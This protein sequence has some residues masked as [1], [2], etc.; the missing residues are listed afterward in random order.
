MVALVAHGYPNKLIA[1]ALGISEQT[2]KN[3]VSSAMRKL[4]ADNRAHAVVLA[5]QQGLVR[6]TAEP[7]GPNREW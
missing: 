7:N 3:H 4:G 2:V 6:I 1:S 5:L